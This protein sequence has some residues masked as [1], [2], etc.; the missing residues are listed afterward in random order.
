MHVLGVIGVRACR[1]IWHVIARIRKLSPS[2]NTAHFVVHQS[3]ITHYF[4]SRN[5]HGRGRG[6][7]R[8]TGAGISNGAGGAGGRA[9]P[10]PSM[11]AQDDRGL[12]PLPSLTADAPPPRLLPYGMTAAALVDT[13]TPTTHSRQHDTSS[14]RH[15]TD[16][17][18]DREHDRERDRERERDSR[19]RDHS[20]RRE[21]SSSSSYRHS[22]YRDDDRDRDRDRRRE[23]NPSSSSSSSS[24]LASSRRHH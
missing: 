21:T 8:S 5:S 6:R 14:R 18:D 1:D 7:G 11:S 13:P 22:P 15:D 12:L 3:E 19:D 10:L 16:R 24:V 9:G 4:T 20:K 17:R 2:M 23:D